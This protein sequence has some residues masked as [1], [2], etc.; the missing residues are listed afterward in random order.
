MI[1]QLNPDNTSFWIVM[2]HD[3]QRIFVNAKNKY[4]H[5]ETGVIYFT[6]GTSTDEIIAQF[7]TAWVMMVS[8][9]RH[10]NEVLKEV[11][12]II[13]LAETEEDIPAGVK[14]Q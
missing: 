12:E 3:G 5:P 2:L 13:Q 7:N 14:L 11:Q 4:E 1:Y 6:N 10:E 8:H 9:E